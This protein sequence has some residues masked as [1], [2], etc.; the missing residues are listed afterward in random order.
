MNK[1]TNAHFANLPGVKIGRSKFDRSFTHK[2]TFNAS[3][4]I[5]VYVDPDILPGDTVTMKQ[6]EIIRMMTPIAP[7]MDNC[8]LDF[9]WWFVPNRIVWNDFKKFM[10][11][12]ETAPWTMTQDIQIP[13]ISFDT[14]D[15][16]T[17]DGET[18]LTKT[19]E[20]GSLIE[21][22]GIPPQKNWTY[23]TNPSSSDYRKI[24]ISALPLRAYCMIWNEFWRDENLQNPV[25]VSKDSTTRRTYNTKTAGYISDPDAFITT[26]EE[27][28]G[29]PPL[30]VCKS[31]DY[32]TSCLPGMQK[33]PSVSIP[34]SEDRQYVRWALDP[35]AGITTPN[36]DG[37]IVRTWNTS[38][39]TVTP[40]YASYS[41]DEDDPW[42]IYTSGTQHTMGNL[43]S[44]NGA[45]YVDLSKATGATITQLRQAFAI[46]K[47]YERDARGGTRYIENVLSHFGVRNPDYRVQRPEYLG[48]FRHHINMNQ[49]VQ[50]T[51]TID[52]GTPLGTTGA[53]SVTSNKN[54]NVFTKSFTEHGIL[55]GLICVRTDHTYQQGINRAWFKKKRLDFYSPEFANLSEMAVLNREIYAQGTTADE[56]AFGYQEAW[57]EMRYMP[58][59]ITGEFRSNYD[60]SLD[61]WH[62]GD[63]YDEKPVLGDK[64]I[65]ETDKNI[66]RTLAV[67]DHNQFMADFYF[68]AIYTRPMPLY[69]IP[70]LI[71]HH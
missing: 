70:G 65:K 36:A 46:Q 2:T 40:M 11:E 61:I 38:G 71:D 69:S 56:E 32:F 54:E 18:Y 1:N 51:P 20:L 17:I 57:A 5:P 4:L 29:L 16:N 10:G 50:S 60:L 30:K 28:G 8:Y 48:G 55:M 64:W 14:T 26:N 13:Q 7:V 52:E 33:G 35:D 9:T 41:T 67:Q 22:M 49:V 63:Y 21:K 53:Y 3:E 25:N 42:Q 15:Y 31:H 12:N 59:M 6:S 68:G 37:K 23:A 39:E 66:E 45:W 62:Y 19:A 43:Q 44:N 24:Q 47:F 58:D 27:R 34:L